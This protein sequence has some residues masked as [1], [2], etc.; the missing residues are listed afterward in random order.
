M[1]PHIV[2]NDDVFSHEGIFFRCGGIGYR[3]GRKKVQQRKEN[4]PHCGPGAGILRVRARLRVVPGR[5][6]RRPSIGSSLSR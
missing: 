1:S 4:V 5:Q 6:K 3:R 2:G